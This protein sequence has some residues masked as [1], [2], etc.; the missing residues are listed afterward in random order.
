MTWERKE[1]PFPWLHL[2]IKLTRSKVDGR[3]FRRR[4][5]AS[6]CVTI[7]FVLGG[8]FWKFWTLYTHTR[9]L[10]LSSRV[11]GASDS[12]LKSSYSMHQWFL[13]VIFTLFF[14]CSCKFVSLSTVLHCWTKHPVPHYTVEISTGRDEGKWIGTTIQGSMSQVALAFNRR[15]PPPSTRCTFVFSKSALVSTYFSHYS[16]HCTALRKKKKF[17]QWYSNSNV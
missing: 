1:T 13:I 17:F 12:R 10:I 9:T 5:W 15:P 8:V 14:F 16:R 3:F 11:M 2:R 7:K 4:W 6:F